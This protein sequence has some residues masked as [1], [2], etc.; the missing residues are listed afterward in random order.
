MAQEQPEERS[1]NEEAEA[2]ARAD[3]ERQSHE[4]IPR[5]SDQAAIAAYLAEPMRG[6]LGLDPS[7][8]PEDLA[9]RMQ[10][11]REQLSKLSSEEPPP[12][13]ESQVPPTGGL[14]PTED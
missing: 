9:N 11:L 14:A 4:R 10:M 13:E 3:M 6:A 8:V 12:L 1:I 2:A 7:K 5:F